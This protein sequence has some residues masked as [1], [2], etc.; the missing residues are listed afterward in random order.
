MGKQP[1]RRKPTR[2][3]KI[4]QANERKRE[5]AMIDKEKRQGYEKR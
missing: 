4:E 3:E 1:E 2:R 5:N